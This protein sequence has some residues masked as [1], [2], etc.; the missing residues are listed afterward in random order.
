MNLIFVRAR[1]GRLRVV[2]A[3][4]A[5]SLLALGVAL[6]PLATTDAHALD[7][8]GPPCPAGGTGANCFALAFPGG[9]TIALNPYAR[10][11]EQL[12]MQGKQQGTTWQLR[13]DQT[14]GSFGIVNRAFGKCLEVRGAAVEEWNIVQA[15]DCQ[16]TPTQKWY[17]HPSGTGF[18]I[19]SAS[20]GRCLEPW[21]GSLL[22]PGYP[23][24]AMACTAAATQR[25]TLPGWTAAPTPRDLAVTYAAKTCEATPT[26]CSWDMKSEAPAAPVPAECVSLPWYNNSPGPATHT[27]G[28]AKTTGWS[29]ELTSQFETAFESGSAPSLIAKVTVKLTVSYKTVWSRSE[30]VNNQMT[31]TIPAG[32]YGWITLN[33]IAR[34]VTGLWTFSA[35]EFPWTAYDTVSV[36]IAHD[37]SGRSTTYGINAGPQPPACRS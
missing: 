16:V 27:F 33:K 25:W 23:V 31:Y 14:D 28:L 4:L 24:G 29:N 21:K 34:K 35:G 15:A 7:L 19:R 22:R 5:T 30:T 12:A 37:S 20:S 8:K 3:S 13:L 1:L 6:G 36:P 32:Q 18:M 11:T 9:E 2:V 26:A 10:F 17:F